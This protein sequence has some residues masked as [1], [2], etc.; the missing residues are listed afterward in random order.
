MA[1]ASGQLIAPFCAD[2]IAQQQHVALALMDSGQRDFEVCC[3][4]HCMAGFL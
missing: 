1:K 3:G 2:G 4:E